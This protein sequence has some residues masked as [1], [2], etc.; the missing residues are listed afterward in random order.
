MIGLI[1]NAG[2]FIIEYLCGGYSVVW[3][4]SVIRFFFG[5]IKKNPMLEHVL[6]LPRG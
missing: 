3:Y 5:L 6:M 1:Q 4:K 2:V